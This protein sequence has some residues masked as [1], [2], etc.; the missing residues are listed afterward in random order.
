ME[1]YDHQGARI[2]IEMEMVLVLDGNERFGP[3]DPIGPVMFV[4]RL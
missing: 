2:A 1:R 4:A 3:Y